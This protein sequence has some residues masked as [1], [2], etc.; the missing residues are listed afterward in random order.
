MKRAALAVLVLGVG[1][2]ACLTLMNRVRAQQDA[3]KDAAKS[4]EQEVKDLKTGLA[5]LA[6]EHEALKE[7]VAKLKQAFTRHT[8]AVKFWDAD[9]KASAAWKEAGSFFITL[10]KISKGEKD[11]DAVEAGGTWGNP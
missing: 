11:E 2:M 8:H 6:K 9:G 1:L 3:P 4:L 7:D 5:N 10:P